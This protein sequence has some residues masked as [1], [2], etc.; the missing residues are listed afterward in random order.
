[1]EQKQ[2]DLYV[3]GIESSP[4]DGIDGKVDIADENVEISKMLKYQ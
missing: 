4:D 2:L 1:L 3:V